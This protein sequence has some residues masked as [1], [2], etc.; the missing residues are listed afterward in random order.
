MP[1][2]VEDT[3]RR[4]FDSPM[5]RFLTEGEKEEEIQSMTQEINEVIEDLKTQGRKDEK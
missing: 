4:Y 5:Y 3:I 1:K 2:N